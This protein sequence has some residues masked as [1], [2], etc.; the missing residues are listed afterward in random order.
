MGRLPPH[1]AGGRHRNP[2]R[3]PDRR[4][5]HTVLLG[6]R[7]AGGGHAARGLRR[8]RAHHRRRLSPT[9][10]EHPHEAHGRRGGGPPRPAPR[11]RPP[12]HWHRRPLESRPRHLVGRR[13]G[14]RRR[15]SARRCRSRPITR[16][17]IYTSGTTGRPKGAVLTQGGFGLKSA[18]DWAYVHR[19][20]RG[21]PDVLADRPGMA[22]GTDAHH[23]EPAARRHRRLV[24]GRAGLPEAGP[25]VVP[26]G[27]PSGHAPGHLAHRGACPHAPRR[28]LDHGPRPVRVAHHRFDRR[29]MEPRALPV[30]LRDGGAGR[31]CP[32]STTPAGRRSRGAFSPASPAPIKPCASPAPSPAWRRSASTMPAS[33]CGARWASWS[34]RSRGPA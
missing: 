17:I 28:G 13:A 14:S 30:A 1:G 34:S 15:R 16:L 2:R 3:V 20:R 7:G 19:R 9:R 32:S 23:R 31:E 21:Q 27:A 11:D 24:R 29:A 10:P 4:R 22:D 26:G 18:H 12:A 25:P 6:L 5:V 33:R 8:A